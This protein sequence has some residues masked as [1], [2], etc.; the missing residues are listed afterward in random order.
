MYC[1]HCLA[2]N[3][4]GATKCV[5]C[6]ASLSDA[7]AG[8]PP[9][10]DNLELQAHGVEEKPAG[11]AAP[12]AR[13]DLPGVPIGGP[14]PK[15]GEEPKKE[16]EPEPPKPPNNQVWGIVT[17]VVSFIS[18]PCGCFSP[19]FGCGGV[20]GLIMGLM[21]ILEA[22]KVKTFYEDKN[23]DHAEASA[24]KARMFA[25]IG[26]GALV[27]MTIA[28]FAYVLIVNGARVFN[29]FGGRGKFE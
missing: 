9:A 26:L 7:I 29:V 15:E 20:L 18:F 3:A 14:P 10:D 21:S 5:Q 19:C 13:P 12:G 4:E 8:A 28:S 23:Y 2:A 16:E 25:M 27:L 17:L 22:Q 24:K 6:G 11:P 1:K